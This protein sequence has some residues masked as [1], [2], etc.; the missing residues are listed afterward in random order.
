MV[1]ASLALLA[2]THLLYCSLNVYICICLHCVSLPHNAVRFSFNF[3][4]PILPLLNP[5]TDCYYIS[6]FVKFLVFLG[7]ILRFSSLFVFLNCRWIVSSFGLGI[8]TILVCFRVLV[9]LVIFVALRLGKPWI[10][11]YPLTYVLLILIRV[12]HSPFLAFFFYRPISDLALWLN[13]SITD[14][15]NVISVGRTW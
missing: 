10:Q 6:L 4:L 12:Q 9:F 1:S 13:R 14:L 15:L 7:H 5:R 2:F 3:N 8:F 11:F